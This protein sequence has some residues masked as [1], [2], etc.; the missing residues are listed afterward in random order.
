MRPFSNPARIAVKKDEEI[1]PYYAGFS[2]MFAEDAIEWATDGDKEKVVLDPWNGS[3]TTTRTASQL[4]I[5]SVGFDLNPVM[6]LGRVE[7]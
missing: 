4:G 5:G 2:R 6:V 3:G 7:I 1:Y